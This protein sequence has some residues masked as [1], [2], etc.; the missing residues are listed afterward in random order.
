MSGE[1]GRFI[2]YVEVSPSKPSKSV[3]TS[4]LASLL[5]KHNIRNRNRGYEL[6]L[7]GNAVE[8]HQQYWL[9]NYGYDIY[10]AHPCSNC[11]FG[12]HSELKGQSLVMV[13]VEMDYGS[14]MFPLPVLCL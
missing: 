5:T 13:E 1:T 7:P 3:D 11:S 12:S 8:Q 10:D 9:N 14:R 4:K 2:R 6:Y